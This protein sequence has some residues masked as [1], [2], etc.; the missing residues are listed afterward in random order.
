MDRFKM[1]E[2]KKTD[3]YILRDV[4]R[5][6]LWVKLNIGRYIGI[7]VVLLLIYCEACMQ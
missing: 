3:I 5:T 7:S 4:G 2:H 1:S 6:Y